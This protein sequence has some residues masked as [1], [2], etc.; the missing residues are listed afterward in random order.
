MTSQKYT[1]NG[2][3]SFEFTG[4]KRGNEI[5]FCERIKRD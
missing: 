4:K 1:F 5:R 2:R 3:F